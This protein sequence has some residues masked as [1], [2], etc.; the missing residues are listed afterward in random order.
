[1]VT[2]SSPFQGRRIIFLPTPGTMLLAWILKVLARGS[3]M[4]CL[5]MAPEGLQVIPA[6]PQGDIGGLSLRPWGCPEVTRGGSWGDTRVTL[7]G[8]QGDPG[9]TMGQVLW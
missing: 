5:G 4:A 1:M 3:E 7:G 8:S 9:V 2:L 6:M